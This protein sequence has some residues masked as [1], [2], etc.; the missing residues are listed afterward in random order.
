MNNRIA[1]H[2]RSA[3]SGSDSEISVEESTDVDLVPVVEVTITLG[4]FISRIDL[5]PSVARM[6]AHHVLARADVLDPV[7]AAAAD[8]DMEC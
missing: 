8:S 1:F 3:R 7:G 4:A 2:G 6:F 5:G